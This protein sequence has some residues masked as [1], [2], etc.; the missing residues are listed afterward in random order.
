MHQGWAD[1][2]RELGHSISQL[3]EIRQRIPILKRCCQK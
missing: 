1:G 2:A 3:E